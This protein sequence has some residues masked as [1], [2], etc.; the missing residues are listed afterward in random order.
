MDKDSALPRWIDAVGA[1]SPAARGYLGSAI[2]AAE[3]GKLS[4]RELRAVRVLLRGLDE[5]AYDSVIALRQWIK[6]SRRP[7]QTVVD[8]SETLGLPVKGGVRLPE[9]VAALY[10]LIDDN[11]DAL[12]GK[13]EAAPGKGPPSPFLE[14]FRQERWRIARLERQR[15]EGAVV[16]V[17]FMRDAMGIVTSTL[18][19]AG[20][21][22]HDQHGEMAYRVLE[23]A[24][25]AIDK[26]VEDMFTRGIDEEAAAVDAE[27]DPEDLDEAQM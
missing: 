15:R 1:L 6:W 8:R 14:L 16:S 3:G 24:L 10:R 27:S 20:T 7:R 18:R 5:G 4:I 12:T 19:R 11:M 25:E 17:P 26:A 9:F 22:L 23:E 13:G 21:R 2:L